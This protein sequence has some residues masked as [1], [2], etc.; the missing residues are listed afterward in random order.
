MMAASLAASLFT[1]SCANYVVN[2]PLGAKLGPYNF[3]SYIVQRSFEDDRMIILSFSGGGTR[4]AALA[5][6]VLKE[7]AS[8][9]LSRKIALISATSG[10]SVT[11]AYYALTGDEGLDTLDAEFLRRDNTSELI[12]IL[13]PRLFFGNRSLS[14]AEYLDE[15]LFN[16]ATYGALIRKRPQPPYV[17]LNATNMSTGTTFEFTQERF[18]HLCSDISRFKLSRAVAASAAVP[19]VMEPITLQNAW[20]DYENCLKFVDPKDPTNPHHRLD[21]LVNQRFIESLRYTF[22]AGDPYRKIEYLHLLDGGLSDNLAARPLLRAFGGAVPGKLMK[23]NVERILVLEGRGI[24]CDI[25]A[26]I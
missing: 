19:F 20:S 17:I 18:L 22:E 25:T 13:L 1:A 24:D 14:F 10:G 11:A 2:E 15:R 7:L 26:T 12:P 21:L 16:G 23:K 6:G 8:K 5:R 3:E 4:A 9:D